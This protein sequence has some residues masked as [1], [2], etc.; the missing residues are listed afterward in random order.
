MKTLIR[1]LS[2]I[3]IFAV[4]LFFV[5]TMTS[6]GSKSDKESDE[7]GTE[8]EHHDQ[9]SEDDHDADHQE[10][11]DTQPDNSETVMWMPGDQPFTGVLKLVQGDEQQ[12]APS[13]SS[14]SDGSKILNLTLN[15]NPVILLAEGAF[16]NVGAN[17]QFKTDGFQGEV[18]IVHHYADPSNYDY[19]SLNNS[20]MQLG[21][22]EGGKNEVMDKKDKK[23][24]GDWS[25]LTVS[26]AGEHYKGLLNK[27]LVN[28]AHGETRPAGQVGIILSGKGKVML[29]MLEIMRLSE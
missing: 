24:P 29:K 3:P 27:E 17:L 10:A 20:A 15:G 11:N 4:S 26:S 23:I 25:T 5:G 8:A 9:S 16:D 28:H 21:R 6:C 7:Q 12:L 18:M 22:M 13:I 19:L 2:L 1:N 14:E